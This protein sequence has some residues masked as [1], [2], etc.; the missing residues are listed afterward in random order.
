MQKTGANMKS[1]C[2]VTLNLAAIL[3]SFTYVTTAA[4]VT[5]EAKTCT[6]AEPI[7][8]QVAGFQAG[9]W[10]LFNQ[11]LV[12]TV[13]NAGKE[14]WV[15]NDVH[16]SFTQFDWNKSTTQ[17]ISREGVTPIFLPETAAPTPPP[18]KTAGGIQTGTISLAKRWFSP[19][20]YLASLLDEYGN[21]VGNDQAYYSRQELAVTFQGN[22]GP[23]NVDIRADGQGFGATIEPNSNE[24][25]G[26]K[27]QT[28]K[29]NISATF[30]DKDPAYS[31]E[32]VDPLAILPSIDGPFLGLCDPTLYNFNACNLA[33]LQEINYLA[34]PMGWDATFPSLLSAIPKISDFGFTFES[35]NIDA[36]PSGGNQVGLEIAIPSNA[37]AGRYLFRIHL[38]PVVGD[39]AQSWDTFAT[40]T[41]PEP[42]G[43]LLMGIGLIVLAGLGRR[44]NS[45]QGL[46]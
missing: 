2:K 41:V 16:L 32:A 37:P 6:G 20:A 4:G 3:I 13:Q 46:A 44:S 26:L 24:G 23:A 38:T 17:W 7:C 42:S 19:D 1:R 15:Q 31:L 10:S 22:V 36:M 11:N 30:A 27:G 39:T 45:P 14:N 5:I 18:N 21:K 29:A 35:L 43:V 12:W 9:G 33:L 40:F 28:I 25:T 34:E 8:G